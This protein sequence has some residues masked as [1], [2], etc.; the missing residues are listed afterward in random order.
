MKDR[1]S[2]DHPAYKF[3]SK[4]KI[5]AYLCYNKIYLFQGHVKKTF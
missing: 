2:R 4:D 5:G 1:G 3:K